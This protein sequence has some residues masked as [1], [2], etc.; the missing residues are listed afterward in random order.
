MSALDASS[1]AGGDV[2]F[3]ALWTEY[4]QY[5]VDGAEVGGGAAGRAVRLW[6]SFQGWRSWPERSDG[7]VG[8]FLGDAP[9]K[10]R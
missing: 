3:A 9:D 8:S 4:T 10:I 2:C 5:T 7:T 6:P 1:A